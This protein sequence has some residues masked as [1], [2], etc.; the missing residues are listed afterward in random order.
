QVDGIKGLAV[1]IQGELVDDVAQVVTGQK[2][3]GHHQEHGYAHQNP[4]PEQNRYG[5]QIILPASHLT[6][7]SLPSR[8]PWGAKSL[9]SLPRLRRPYRPPRS[10]SLFSGIPRWSAPDLKPSLRCGS[11]SPRSEWTEPRP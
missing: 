8:L 9:R 2:A 7:L 1:V 5:Q 6:S 3:D 11:A 4:D 10:R